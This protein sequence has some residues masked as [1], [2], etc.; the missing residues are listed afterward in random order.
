[1]QQ[2]ASLVF[3]FYHAGGHVLLSSCLDG[4]GW[5]VFGVAEVDGPSCSKRTGAWCVGAR[6][7]SIIIR[8]SCLRERETWFRGRTLA[9][10]SC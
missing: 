7:T 9:A 5:K 2:D 4:R 3:P 8:H 6:A 10:V 1:M